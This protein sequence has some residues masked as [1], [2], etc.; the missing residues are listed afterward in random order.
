[1]NTS[2]TTTPALAGVLFGDAEHLAPWSVLAVSVQPESQRLGYCV[3]LGKAS[4]DV[5]IVSSPTDHS[6]VHIARVRYPMRA[7]LDD[8]DTATALTYSSTPVLYAEYSGTPRSTL[9]S[10]LTAP[11]NRL[12][13]IAY[14]LRRLGYSWTVT[15]EVYAAATMTGVAF[16]SWR[17]T[18]TDEAWAAYDVLDQAAHRLERRDNAT[19]DMLAKLLTGDAEYAADDTRA[20]CAWADALRLERRDAV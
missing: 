15:L 11:G 18:A 13:V 6:C 19:V 16:A 1:V 14:M 20:L 10:T 17:Q 3:P 8:L 2:T 12:P 5:S 9:S 4:A 7:A